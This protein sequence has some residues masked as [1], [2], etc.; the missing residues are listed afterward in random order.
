[1][2]TAGGRQIPVLNNT[3]A[4]TFPPENTE[5]IYACECNL[6]VGN[7]FV[8]VIAKHYHDDFFINPDGFNV[9]TSDIVM[10]SQPGLDIVIRPVAILHV[11]FY[12]SRFGAS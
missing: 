5:T 7:D 10:I 9:L 2:L 11:V 1:M 3:G 12:R 6:F 8:G 4:C